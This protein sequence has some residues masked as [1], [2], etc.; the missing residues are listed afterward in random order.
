MTYFDWLVYQISPDHFMRERYSELLF[1]L[2]STEFFWVLQRD[3]NRAEDGLE[4]RKKFDREIGGDIDILGPCTCLEMMVALAIRCENELMYDPDFGDRTDQWFWMMIENLGLDQ[5]DD[6]N[7]DE[8]E[9]DY[10]LERFMKREYGIHGKYCMFPSQ[11]SI[12]E[13]EKMELAYQINFYV[14]EVFY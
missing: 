11:E 12:D 4:L 7:F 6:D 9:I 13:L 2:Y 5:F 1:A 3:R 8:D 10:I 14:K